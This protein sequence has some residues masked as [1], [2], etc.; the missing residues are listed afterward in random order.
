IAFDYCDAG[1]AELTYEYISRV[2]I[3]SIDN[4]SGKDPGGY[5][6]FTSQVTELNR[7]ST[8]DVFV[9]NGV[10]Y[11]AD[12]VIVYVDWN[13]D[14]DFDDSG[15]LVFHS[16]P[17][18]TM[19]FEGSFTVPL[20]APL[21]TTRMRV[22]LHDSDNGPLSEACGFSQWG[23]VEDYSLRISEWNPC[24]ALNYLEYKA[25]SIPGDY[26]SLGNEG[27]VIATAD[28]DNANSDPQDIGFSFK[29][30]CEFFSQFVLN[31]NGFIKLG[32]TPPSTAALFYDDPRV[33][34]SGIF[35]NNNPADINL[36][37]PMNIDLGP[38][39]GT[40]EYRVHTS[41]TAPNRVCTIQFK[42]VREAGSSPVPQFDNMQ[43]QIKLYEKSNI[44]E[45]VYGDWTPSGNQDDLRPVACGLK[46]S[47]SSDDQLLI[48][49]KYTHQTWDDVFFTNSNNEIPAAIFYQEPPLSPKPDAGRTFRFNPR[50]DN[51]LGIYEIY[52]LGDA[53]LYYSNPQPIAVNVVNAGKTRLTDIPVAIQVTGDNFYV[54]SV[55]IPSLA[56]DES[57]IVSFPDLVATNAGNSNMYVHVVNDQDEDSSNNELAWLQNTNEYYCNYS[58]TQDPAEQRSFS[59]QA[60]RIYAAKYPISGTASIASVTAY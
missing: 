19:V 53:S 8:T 49:S 9:E 36:L 30:N 1:A 35:E 33:A 18:G 59:P 23:E 6:D 52:S 54:E 2:T 42:D 50:Y 22:R 29:Y 7:G 20:A 24:A 43:F 51:D 45:F 14:G 37:S 58:S 12:E 60:D 27:T 11:V 5:T 39:T 32:N 57:V 44:I 4:P 55:I 3:G 46:G 10:P 38:G 13:I 25:S 21:G 31:T 40:P 41:G 47:D 56:P 16:D 48:V 28:F 15:E 17:S 26:V 34:D